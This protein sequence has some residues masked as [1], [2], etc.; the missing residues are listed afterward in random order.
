MYFSAGDW[1]NNQITYRQHPDFTCG[2][3]LWMALTAK[4]VYMSF[5][6]SIRYT[7]IYNKAFSGLIINKKLCFSLYTI[8]FWIQTLMF[9]NAFWLDDWV[10]SRTEIVSCGYYMLILQI[11]PFSKLSMIGM[12]LLVIVYIHDWSPGVHKHSNRQ[13]QDIKCCSATMQRPQNWPEFLDLTLLPEED[14]QGTNQEL[15][16]KMTI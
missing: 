8:N 16:L 10:N 3:I 13:K 14:T 5:T 9:L 4:H 15:V 1:P 12:F 7:C 2:M 11:P 6:R